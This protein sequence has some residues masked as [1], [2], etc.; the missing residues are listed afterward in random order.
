M[1]TLFRFLCL[2][3]CAAMPVSAGENV[4]VD[5]QQDHTMSRFEI[6]LALG[7]RLDNLRT[8]ER[9]FSIYGALLYRLHPC[10]ATQGGIGY[11]DV[12]F[13][14]DSRSGSSLT[15]DLLL[16][17]ETNQHV[18]T[19]YLLAG[20]GYRHNRYRSS[21]Y[22]AGEDRLGAV[23]GVGM[24]LSVSE[25]LALDLGVRQEIHEV[26]F[27]DTYYSTFPAPRDQL[28]GLSYSVPS[29]MRNASLV[30][31]QLRHRL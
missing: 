27:A 9:G 4:T 8:I 28:P 15:M 24:A 29:V 6:G 23:L 7:G 10:I 19:P 25:K 5:N 21:I 31:I 3:L 17:V 13:K 11:E 1:E 2:V 12:A 14:D 20:V 16:R 22:E 26:S 30:T 18:I